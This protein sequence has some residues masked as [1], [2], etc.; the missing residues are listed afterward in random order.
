MFKATVK[1]V[2]AGFSK[3]TFRGDRTPEST[4]MDEAFHTLADYRD[5]AVFLAHYAGNSEW[6]RH[7]AGDELVMALE[8]YTTLYLLVEGEEV[9]FPLHAGELIVVPQGTWHRFESPDPVKIMTV[10]PA[11]TDHSIERP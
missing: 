1:S 4:D 2:E 9:P 10:T 5:G 8:G 6:E 3:I 11:P 7:S